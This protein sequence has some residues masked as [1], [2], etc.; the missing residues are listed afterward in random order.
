[1]VVIL[2]WHCS[3]NIRP[4]GGSQLNSLISFSG[5]YGGGRCSYLQQPRYES[6]TVVP[7]VAATSKCLAQKSFSFIPTNKQPQIHFFLSP[8]KHH[9]FQQIHVNSHKYIFLPPKTSTTRTKMSRLESI[10]RSPRPLHCA[11]WAHGRS[12]TKTN[13]QVLPDAAERDVCRSWCGLSN[14]NSCYNVMPRW[15]N[16][17]CRGGAINNAMVVQSTTREKK[18]RKEMGVRQQHPLG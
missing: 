9:S 12:S 11:A 13:A 6:N 3:H 15:C 17:Q 1:M 14:C 4:S 5:R 7:V 10:A 18:Q 2:T 8:R 16:Q